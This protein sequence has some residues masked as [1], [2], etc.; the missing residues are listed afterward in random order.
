MARMQEIASRFV[1]LN[2][3]QPSVVSDNSSRP[4]AVLILLTPSVDFS[5]TDLILIRRPLWLRHHPGQLCFPGGK[6]DAQDS[7]LLDTALR[8]TKEELGISL[9]AQEIL[10]TLPQRETVSGFT[11]KP[12]I[13]AIN[14][15]PQFR[16]CSAEVDEVLR[17]PLAPFMAPGAF[18]L[19]HGIRHKR[20]FSTPG[21]VVNDQLIW[22][23]TARIL[24]DFVQHLASG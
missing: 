12:Y 2:Q 8:E 10:G 9:V 20:S 7:S 3:T 21:I 6:Q 14:T 23:A 13:M 19:W 1:M 22:G 18:G 15:L 4:A 11:I 17:L 5:N 24:M 16:P